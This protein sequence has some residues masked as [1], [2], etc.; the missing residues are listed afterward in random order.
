MDW[1]TL[2]VQN[3]ITSISAAFIFGSLLVVF[4]QIRANNK[5]SRAQTYQSIANS[6]N[7][8]ARFA[9]SNADL[10][11]F[12]STWKHDPDKMPNLTRQQARWA[13]WTALDFWE[14]LFYQHEQGMLPEPLW[15]DHWRKS[16]EYSAGLEGFDSYWK[17]VK[18]RYY[19]EFAKFVDSAR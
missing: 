12:Y 15:E 18:S 7:D 3:I 19:K 16:I 2:G 10:L 9:M 6:A 8:F 13:A 1:G 5:V 14:N 4:F 17:S 11:E